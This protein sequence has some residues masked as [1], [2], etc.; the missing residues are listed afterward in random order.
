M[1]THTD[2]PSISSL[3]GP[4]RIRV[5]SLRPGDWVRLTSL[6]GR[7]IDCYVTQNYATI[8]RIEICW[9]GNH[10]QT[11]AHSTLPF[12]SSFAYLGRGTDRPWRKHLPR[13]L[14]SFFSRYNKPTA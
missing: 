2:P 10:L 4:R 12:A 8:A 1:N 9:P 3:L 7:S 14:R 5:S 6:T 11:L 13:C